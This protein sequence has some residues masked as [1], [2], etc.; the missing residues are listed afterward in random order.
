MSRCDC[1][2]CRVRRMGM[3]RAITEYVR[4]PIPVRDY[5]W[6]AVFENY[7]P[8]QPMGWGPTKEA[9]VADLIE[10]QEVRDDSRLVADAGTT[11]ST[12]AAA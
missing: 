11:G 6:S 3:G 7:E 10:Q 2:N 5:D 9:A 12:G 1:A 8:G 4:P